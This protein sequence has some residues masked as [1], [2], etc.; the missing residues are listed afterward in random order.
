MD[1]RRRDQVVRHFRQGELDLLVATNV[2]ARG[3]DIPE[4][5]HVVNFDVPQNAEEYVHRVGRT[6][7]AGRHGTAITLVSEHDLGE[8]DVLLAVFGDRMRE[9]RLELY[10]PA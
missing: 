2:A 6:G 5:T 4:I 10:E 7:R 8:F 1:Q 9:E 3:L